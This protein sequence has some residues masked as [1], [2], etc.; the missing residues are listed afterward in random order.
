MKNLFIILGICSA[1]LS[2]PEVAVGLMSELPALPLQEFDPLEIPEGVDPSGTLTQ[3]MAQRAA[4]IKQL[5]QRLSGQLKSLE[6]EP[7][8]PAGQVELLVVSEDESKLSALTKQRANAARLDFAGRR[9]LAE[10]G[11]EPFRFVFDSF[12]RLTAAELAACQSVAEQIATLQRH[13]QIARD[14]ESE[15]VE[16]LLAGLVSSLGP[17]QASILRL[18]VE[19]QLAR[20]L[21]EQG[22]ELEESTGQSE[23][24]ST[25]KNRQPWR[26]LIDG[27]AGTDNP[28]MPQIKE[29]L[30]E[31]TLDDSDE[32]RRHK[33][34]TNAA[35][36]YERFT[37]SRYSAD[38]GETATVYCQA[39]LRR[40]DAEG[41]LQGE[42][43]DQ[44]EFLNRMWKLAREFELDSLARW[45]A[46]V[47]G[48]EPL[49]AASVCR[50]ELQRRRDKLILD[51]GPG[52]IP[53][54]ERHEDEAQQ[55]MMDDWQANLKG[56][57]DAS[58][59]QFGFDEFNPVA[60]DDEPLI[61][62]TKQQF[63]ALAMLTQSALQ[64]TRSGS[65]SPELWIL[66][67]MRM[68][69]VEQELAPTAEARQ[70]LFLAGLEL[71]REQE[72]S[73]LFKAKSGRVPHVEI[74]GASVN[75]LDRELKLAQS[76]EE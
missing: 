51:L 1:F 54:A 23:D 76:N 32:L 44:V 56:A 69:D 20:L 35:I 37:L 38:G 14:L 70:E 21:D 4:A 31:V 30:Y 11:V 61:Q 13:H 27:K 36:V 5:E 40:V 75:R 60:D 62:L 63:N 19:D 34:L 67:Q 29:S 49:C 53:E 39:L 3:E 50:L 17:A 52:E 74:W 41:R 12:M 15:Q 57:E 10:S 42:G 73:M 59:R 43:E 64:K 68:L 55:K 72:Q 46:G 2:V 16:Q 22:R 47:S 26:D 7:A 33:Q 6:G 48:M 8:S 71:A 45:N 18:Q 25:A 9:Q 65:S 28:W 24:E 58:F 66:A